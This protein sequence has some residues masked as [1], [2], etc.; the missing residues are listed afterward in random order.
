[1][2]VVFFVLKWSVRPRVDF[3]V[4][5]ATGD[6]TNTSSCQPASRTASS[7]SFS[8]DW[9]HSSSVSARCSAHLPIKSRPTRPMCCSSNQAW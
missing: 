3:L 7:S 2:F 1:M 8:D 4:S 6:H 9:V 5:R